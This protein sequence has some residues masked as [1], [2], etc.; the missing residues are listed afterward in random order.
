PPDAFATVHAAWLYNALGKTLVNWSR[1]STVTFDLGG[2]STVASFA[3]FVNNH[4]N[5]IR[6]QLDP[7]LQ[8]FEVRHLRLVASDAFG[9][10]LRLLTVDER[11][12]GDWE[13]P[14]EAPGIVTLRLAGKCATR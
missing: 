8:L 3:A 11:L 6:I 7:A 12:C 1:G 14:A 5:A 13:W 4:Q 9:L 2:N 10:V